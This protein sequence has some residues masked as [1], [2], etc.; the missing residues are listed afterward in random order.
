[1]TPKKSFV[2]IFTETENFHLVKDVGQV[3]FFVH[4][5]GIY[6]GELVSYQNNAEYPYLEDEVKGL[7][8][9]FINKAGHFISHQK[10]IL[11]FLISSSKKIDILNLFH[12]KRENILYLLVYKSLNPKGRA[13]VKLDMDILFFK[14]YNSFFFSNYKLKNYLLK[15]L[16]QAHFK[17]T[18]LFS[19]ETEE[20]AE[21][22]KKVYPELENKLICVPNGVDNEFIDRSIAVKTFEKKENII[23]TVGRIGTDQKNTELFLESLLLTDLEDWKVYIIGPIEKSFEPYIKNYFVKNPDLKDKI[24]FTGNISDRKE[25]FDWYNRAKVFCMT[26]RYEGFPLA[27]SEALYFG[28]YII[29]APLS[30]SSFVTDH[31]RLG[32][33]SEAN[34]ADFAAAIKNTIA[35]GFLKPDLYQAIRSFSKLNLT[36]PRIIKRIISHFGENA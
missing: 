36:W 12:F 22:L 25:I 2:T 1:M 31:G 29:T 3:P 16:V 21:Y 5:S 18:D 14:N 15:G 27:F 13:Y 32:Y 28:N 24:F 34:P 17:L 6:N 4:K 26:S 7:K 20:A 8:L 9:T 30:C 11:K 19:V 33:V 35:K 23:L 10:S